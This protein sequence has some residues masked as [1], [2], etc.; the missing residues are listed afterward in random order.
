M[1]EDQGITELNGD[2]IDIAYAIK[3]ANLW[4][5]QSREHIWYAR[6]EVE[7]GIESVASHIGKIKTI[8][9]LSGQ[10]SYLLIWTG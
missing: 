3:H 1:Q 2:S 10:F 4:I 5:I 9:Y 8:C 7:I 6:D